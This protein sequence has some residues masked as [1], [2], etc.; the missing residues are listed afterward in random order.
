MTQTPNRSTLENAGSE[1]TIV[2]NACSQLYLEPLQLP[3]QTFA[4]VLAELGSHIF[5]FAGHGR[6]DARGPS[7]SGLLLEDGVLTVG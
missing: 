7:Q 3:D 5:H 1:V 6:S 2:Q 4:A